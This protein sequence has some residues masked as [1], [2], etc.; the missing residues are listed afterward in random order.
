[1]SDTPEVPPESDIR[2]DPADKG[3][4]G[5]K[6][7]LFGLFL[8]VVL[9]IFGFS[10]IASLLGRSGDKGLALLLFAGVVQLAW[11]LPAILLMRKDGRR[12]VSKG[13]AI[14]AAIT[15]LLNATCW[16]IAVAR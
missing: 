4:V 13:L 3:P 8:T 7:V 1:V 2:P 11:M 5:W 12:A 15:L 9:H 16:V 10:F 14:G 6:G